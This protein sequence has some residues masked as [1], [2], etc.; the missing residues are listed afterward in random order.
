M[1]GLSPAC[2][3]P[4]SFPLWA[5]YNYNKKVKDRLHQPI[6][7]AHAGKLASCERTPLFFINWRDAI[8]NCGPFV[9]A[10]R[11]KWI[12]RAVTL[13][14]Q[15]SDN[16]GFGVSNYWWVGSMYARPEQVVG[17]FS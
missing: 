3:L 5:N 7:F 9:R 15:V 2:S 10:P 14:T 11:V 13:A 4:F 12:W 8:I 6:A 17:V 1:T 16:H